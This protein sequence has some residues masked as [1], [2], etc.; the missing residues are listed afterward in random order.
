MGH[1]YCNIDDINIKKNVR[2]AISK[3][4]HIHEVSLDDGEKYSPKIKK[5]K[6]QKI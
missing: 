1:Q 3:E 2:F 6:L 4:I 5:K